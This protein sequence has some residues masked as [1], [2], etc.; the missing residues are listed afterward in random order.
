M[1]FSTFT[2]AWDKL[3]D[4]LEVLNSTSPCNHQAV[5]DKLTELEE[6]NKVGFA[7][8]GIGACPEDAAAIFANEHNVIPF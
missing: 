5:S 4:E 1:M 8:F 7:Q 2:Q 6:L 3:H